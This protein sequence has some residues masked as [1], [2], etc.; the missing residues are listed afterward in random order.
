MVRF[1]LKNKITRAYLSGIL[2][3][4]KAGLN[5][6]LFRIRGEVQGKSLS[7]GVMRGITPFIQSPSAETVTG[8]HSLGVLGILI[9][10]GISFGVAVGVTVDPHII[11]HVLG[12]PQ[13]VRGNEGA[14]GRVDQLTP[15]SVTQ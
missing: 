7:Q 2:R 14:H 13:N 8:D 3:A 11:R 4:C 15:L 5:Q 6:K 12:V 10:R 1:A 9:W